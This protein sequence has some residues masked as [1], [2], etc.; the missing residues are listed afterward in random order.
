MLPFLST[1]VKQQP[2]SFRYYFANAS[3][4]GRTKV[5]CS[6]IDSLSLRMS[7]SPLSLSLY[8]SPDE[9][10]V[11]S[12][13]TSYIVPRKAL[14]VEYDDTLAGTASNID[15]SAGLMAA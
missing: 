9:W 4:S 10:T 15:T 8:L 3:R 6:N 2:N 11:A 12:F 7:R 5:T 14:I 1:L 13:R